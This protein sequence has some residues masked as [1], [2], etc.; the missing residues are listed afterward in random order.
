MAALA[1]NVG[2]AA[3]T[4]RVVEEMVSTLGDNA[5]WFLCFGL[6]I[7]A[8]L[9]VR[10]GHADAAI[11]LVREGLLRIRALNDRFSLMYSLV[12]LAAAAVLKGNDAWAARILGTRDAV[13]DRTGATLADPSVHAL[14]AETERDVRARLGPD[15]WAEAYA[16]G[17]KASMDTLLRDIDGARA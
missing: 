3:E 16:A 8:I 1:L 2:D 12:P 7:R 11:G 14:R 5:P 15:R 13:V 17:R 4:E 6:W 9:A 10:Q